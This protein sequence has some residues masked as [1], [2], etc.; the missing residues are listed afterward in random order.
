MKKIVF[1]VLIACFA[2]LVYGQ[3]NEPMKQNFTFKLDSLGNGSV[4][5]STKLTAMQW[6]QW[7][8]AYGE[9]NCSRLK[10]D[11]ERSLNTMYLSDFDYKESEM[12]RSWTLTFK[13]K[14]IAKYEGDNKWIA[15]LGIKNPEISQLNDHSFLL[16]STYNEGGVLI[17]Q[18]NTILFPQSASDVKQ[19]KDEFGNATFD[20][21]LKP[22]MA[23]SGNFFYI[24]LAFIGLSLISALI[25]MFQPK[26][27]KSRVS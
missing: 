13:A 8:A 22:V 2:A 20:Y 5:I 14:G 23:R 16:T 27:A 17:N 21:S 19:G 4:S 12:D 10:R 7:E 25:I 3:G 18:S 6:Q 11:I 26:T 24:G 15:E 9:K 1:T